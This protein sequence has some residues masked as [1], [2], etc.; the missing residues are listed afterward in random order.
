[1][2]D[3]DMGLELFETCQE[4][5]IPVSRSQDWSASFFSRNY[6]PHF[7]RERDCE[8]FKNTTFI[9]E[10]LTNMFLCRHSAESRLSSAN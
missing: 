8:E 10:I 1:M 7:K 9:L 5:P 6:G 2:F 4:I 3:P